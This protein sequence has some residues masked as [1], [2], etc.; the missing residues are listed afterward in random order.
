MK[1][2]GILGNKRSGKSK[3]ICMLKDQRSTQTSPTMG[4]EVHPMDTNLTVYEF[5]EFAEVQHGILAEMDGFIY[6]ANSKKDTFHSDKPFTIVKTKGK[7]RIE[8]AWEILNEL[9]SRI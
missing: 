8:N 2:I 4:L 1:K 6:I 9:K 3:F 7:E 5:G